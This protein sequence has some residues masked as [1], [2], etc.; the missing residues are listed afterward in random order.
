MQKG[1]IYKVSTEAIF[2]QKNKP[3]MLFKYQPITEYSIANL[4]SEKLWASLPESFNDPF[5]YKHKVIGEPGNTEW[6]ELYAK[7]DNVTIICLT[8]VPDDLLMWAHYA[9][10]HYGFC[11]GFEIS[12][13][14]TKVNYSNNYPTLDFTKDKNNQILSW[15]KILHSKSK[16]WK[17]EKEH[18]MIFVGPESL[19]E[20]PGILTTIIFGFKTK[21]VDKIKILKI[22]KDKVNYFQARLDDN[23]YKINIYEAEIDI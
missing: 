23:S 6:D 5:E 12:K 14:T 2:Q 16:H 7:K 19:R 22:L 15:H 3:N 8:E 17:Y 4:I 20:Y 11:M 21:E 13:L 18:R 1:K 10:S 9:D